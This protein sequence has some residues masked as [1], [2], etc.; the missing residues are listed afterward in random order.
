[1]PQFSW[2]ILSLSFISEMF[3]MFSGRL[4]TLDHEGV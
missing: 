2:E 4:L 3:V 1:M